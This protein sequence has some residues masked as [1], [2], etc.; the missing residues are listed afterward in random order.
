M[1]K[2]IPDKPSNWKGISIRIRATFESDTHIVGSARAAGVFA[3]A[4]GMPKE[5]APLLKLLKSR[6]ASQRR[7]LIVYRSGLA[8]SFVLWKAVVCEKKVG[9]AEL[10]AGKSEGWPQTSTSQATQADC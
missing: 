3:A 7:C 10:P 8:V 9:G 6:S 2:Y 4:A 5:G 1:E